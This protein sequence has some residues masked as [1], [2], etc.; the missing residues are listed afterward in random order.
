MLPRVVWSGKLNHAFATIKQLVI[1]SLQSVEKLT[2]LPMIEGFADGRSERRTLCGASRH[3]V[4]RLTC[5]S[6]LVVIGSR[7]V[8]AIATVP[9]PSFV[10]P[11]F[12][13]KWHLNPHRISGAIPPN[14]LNPGDDD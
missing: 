6:R 2:L 8:R 1:R 9:A 11:I 12:S 3:F 14:K 10:P 7:P 4:L 13:N 5:D